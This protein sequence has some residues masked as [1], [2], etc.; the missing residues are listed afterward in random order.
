MNIRYILI[1]VFQIFVAVSS[2]DEILNSKQLDELFITTEDIRTENYE[3]FS[4]NLELLA[5]NKSGFTEFQKCYYDYL[6]AYKLSFSGNFQSATKQLSILSN[7]CKDIRIKIRVNALLANLHAIAGDYLK[8]ISNLDQIISFVDDNTD[9]ISNYLAYTSAFIVYD[10]VDQSELSL[11]FANLLIDEKPPEKY[12][13]KGLLYK[14]KALLESSYQ[15]ELD[16][17]VENIVKQCNDAGETLYAQALNLVWFKARLGV[18]STKQEYNAL[19]NEIIESH[20]QVEKTQYQNLIS[21]KN[22]L[23]AEVYEKLDS[24]EKAFEYANLAI[25]GSFTIGTTEQKID[26]LQV[27]INYY[28]RNENHREAN[29]YLIEKNNVEIKLYT[30]KQAKLMAYQTIRHNNL[31]NSLQIESLNQRNA[32][33]QLE[34]ELAEQS[35]TNQLLLNSL[36]G[37]IILFL[38][39]LGYRIYKQQKLYKRLS[40]RDPMTKIY[41]RKG[42]KDYMDYLL[43]Y[44]K[45]KNENVA[46]GIFDLDLFKRINDE[47]GHAVGDWVIKTS[48]MVCKGLGNNK[49]TFARLGGEE[50][51]LIINDSNLKE[52]EQFSEECRLAIQKISTQE[53]TGFDFKI[54]ASFGITTTEISGY[55]YDDLMQNA[56]AALYTAKNA[57][58]NQVKVYQES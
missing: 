4:E 7:D 6:L 33:L 14:Y 11:K 1:I 15:K 51:A 47:Y 44:S 46:Y 21:I 24:S 8:A 29:K 20:K 58:R 16:S 40:E 10:M 50:F 35:K 43:P 2:A 28:Q 18:Y 34:K 12:L 32:L 31:A 53:E 48:V 30:D 23:F 38:L 55:D 37:I 13:C 56:D 27:L 19:L 42:I 5:E 49:V 57:G 45:N 54:S 9:K 25:K 22:A 52:I 41:N 17:E 26:A 36:L 3:K 39:I